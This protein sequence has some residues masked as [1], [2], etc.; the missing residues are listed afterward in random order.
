MSNKITTFAKRL[1]EGLDV[2]H[3]TQAELSKSSGISKSSISRYLSGAWE[4]KQ[5][6]V[7]ALAKV[8]SVNEAW[9]MGYDVPMERKPPTKHEPDP[10]TDYT[11]IKNILPLPQ[12]VKQ[13]PLYDGIACGDPRYA[14]DQIVD[15]MDLPEGV[16]ADFALRCYGDSMINAH[17]RD[18]DIVYIRKQEDVDDGEIAA[19]LVDDDAT[20]KRVY[21]KPY[22]ILLMPANDAFEPIIYNGSEGLTVR[23]LG[24]AVA[25][26]S[27]VR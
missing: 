18:G 14:D 15:M 6:A 19:V 22:G 10:K 4:G 11:K 9:L 23:I 12:I 16:R 3:M 7:Y 25:C 8:L 21:H 5:D 2:R 13:V 1:R 24:K 20:L 26:L 27:R 17:I